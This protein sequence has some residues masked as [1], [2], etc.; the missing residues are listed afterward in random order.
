MS[1]VPKDVELTVRLCRG[2][3]MIGD[4]LEL[5][6]EVF[7]GPYTDV[8]FIRF[9]VDD[10]SRANFVRI[11]R[12]LLC[13]RSGDGRYWMRW[14]SF[15][16]A[17]RDIQKLVRWK[18]Y[19]FRADLLHE[20]VLN[21]AAE[22]E[23][24]EVAESIAPDDPNW[25]TAQTL[26]TSLPNHGREL[27]HKIIDEVIAEIRVLEQIRRYFDVIADFEFE[28]LM[29]YLREL[30]IERQILTVSAALEMQHRPVFLDLSLVDFRIVT[31]PD[32]TSTEFQLLER[33]R[34]SLIERSGEVYVNELLRS[35]D[36]AAFENGV[37]T[38]TAP[39][40]PKELDRLLSTG[41]H[42]EPIRSFLERLERIGTQLVWPYEKGE[43]GEF[44]NVLFKDR[45]QSPALCS[46]LP[47]RYAQAVTW[48]TVRIADSARK[49]AKSGARLPLELRELIT[50]SRDLIRNSSSTPQA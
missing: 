1:N 13:G 16:E 2:E 33:V 3:R 23:V 46:D 17:W 14:T 22:L 4:N 12:E 48:F 29:R 50:R 44:V 38:G 10:K 18:N 6:T 28:Y 49:Y 5:R 41:R 35:V 39:A 21:V 15:D 20:V 42:L 7:N 34:E 8:E 27:G 26:L 31:L 43:L 40:L 32:W 36:T 37:V 19:R 30:P 9:D 47:N 25:A 11:A 45:Q 24:W